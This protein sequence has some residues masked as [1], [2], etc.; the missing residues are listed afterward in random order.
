MCGDVGVVHPVH[1]L[2]ELSSPQLAEWIAYYRTEPRGED[3][4]DWRI[5]KLAAELVRVL[6]GRSAAAVTAKDF[7]LRFDEPRA[8]AP[9]DADAAARAERAHELLVKM[10]QIY[11]PAPNP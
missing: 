11:P 4:D 1:L 9:V 10:Q 2:R 3:R 8:A 6:C 5:A 7:L